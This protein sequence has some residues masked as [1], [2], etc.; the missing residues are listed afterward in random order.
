[1][2]FVKWILITYIIAHN[3]RN[4]LQYCSQTIHQVWEVLSISVNGKVNTN[5]II[6]QD[7]N[8]KDKNVFKHTIIHH[9]LPN[10]N[11]SEVLHIKEAYSSE[12][13]LL[14][15]LVD[16]FGKTTACSQTAAGLLL[17]RHH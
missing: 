1:M 7:N 5:K 9:S 12:K 13:L 6:L 4:S 8:F 2:I 10:E 17:P 11:R 16:E 14:G 15:A 3:S